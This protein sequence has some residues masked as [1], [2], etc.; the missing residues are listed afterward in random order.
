MEADNRAARSA[1]DDKWADYEFSPATQTAT[2]LQYRVGLLLRWFCV[3]L[4]TFGLLVF[5][6]NAFE[7]KSGFFS[8]LTISLFSSGAVSLLL[9][10]GKA[11]LIG[12]GVG[13]V[14]V[15][16]SMI[17][18][19]NLVSYFRGS[20]L[21]T[22]DSA[23]L[24]LS[25]FGFDN[26][27]AYVTGASDMGLDAAA[28]HSG[29]LTL[30]AAVLSLI[31]GLCIVRRVFILPVL[32]LS[33]GVL[34]T[35]FIVN[36]ASSNWGFALTVVALCGAVVMKSFDRRFK[37]K[38]KDRLASASL[39]GYAGGA[40]MLL[41]FLALVIP[42]AVTKD[43]WRDIG[44][45]SEPMELAR[46][47]VE[48]VVSGDAPNLKDLGLVENMDEGN[49]RD[50]AP[51]EMSYTG[52]TVM[53]VETTY[54]KAMPI[55]LRG[56]VSTAYSGGVWSTVTNDLRDRYS[57]TVGE[58]AKQ[59][60]LDGYSTEYMTEAFYGMLDPTFADK[61]DG[62]FANR[63]RDGFISMYV[64]VD[65]ELGSGTGNLIYLPTSTSVQTGL[66]KHGDTEKPY[67]SSSTKPYFDGMYVTGWL[68]MN[69]KYTAYTHVPVMSEA[70]FGDTFERNLAYYRAMRALMEEHRELGDMTREYWFLREQLALEACGII[71]GEGEHGAY[72]TRYLAMSEE[73]QEL[74]YARYVTTVD[75]YTAYVKELYGAIAAEDKNATLSGYASRVLTDLGEDATTHEK[76]LATVQF[77]VKNYKYSMNPKLP[78]SVEGLDG[79]LRETK[80]GYCVQFATAVT[81]MLREMGIP[82]RYV[83]G[84]IAS[85]FAKSE[86]TGLYTC[87]VTDV[88]AHAWVEVYYEG[89]GWLPYETTSAYARGYYGDT[90][91]VSGGGSSSIPGASLGGGSAPD[92]SDTE[93]ELPS[94]LPPEQND[95]GNGMALRVL[96]ACGVIAALGV[97]GFFLVRWLRDRADAVMYER[98]RRITAALNREVPEEDMGAVA[99]GINAQILDLFAL[100]GHEPKEGE[101]PR[102]FAKRM[103][104]E[105]QLITN[106]PLEAIMNILQKQEFGNGVDADELA[107]LAEYLD[108]LWKEVYRTESGARRLWYRYILCRL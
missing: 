59:A 43:E 18:H 6:G 1:T 37:V 108:A 84:Y 72:F 79:F 95:S 3:F 55:Y 94:E 28:L 67:K 15:L 24:R 13:A 14:G 103:D 68:N 16:L 38:R 2:D 11:S 17:G 9:I 96:I 4:L 93:E 5:L 76:V 23:M 91:T 40:A 27:E 58:V 34:T 33:I 102:E 70:E 57:S 50:T 92:H 46:A 98:R 66:L 60:G 36:I 61:L 105:A 52:E 32:L 62:G 44:F 73:E 90:I 83:E 47:V 104:E 81:L 86:E 65:M 35:G 42:A 69:K 19:S 75:A 56:W 99:N 31:F 54:D 10:G 49:S 107:V 87:D 39:G 48:S 45:I 85:R 82:A 89:Y 29:A 41:A 8:L 88:Q 20:V 100:A 106:A 63:Y 71:L 97:G 22:F 53:T 21:Y 30:I 80:Q 64:N 25:G 78:V 51:K 12:L 7:L 26:F 74:E 77:M 101:L